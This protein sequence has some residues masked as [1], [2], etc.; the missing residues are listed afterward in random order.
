MAVNSNWPC[1]EIM[2]CEGTDSCSA[3][4]NPGKH[5]WEIAREKEDYRSAFNI[6]ND[7]IVFLLKQDDPIL[8]KREIE[9]IMEKKGACALLT[10]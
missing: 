3:K 1:W 5:C 7:C 4:L 10:V 9:V 6:C 2:K 8:T